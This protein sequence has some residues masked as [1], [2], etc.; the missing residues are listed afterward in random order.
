[1][2]LE[3]A[4]LFALLAGMIFLFLTEK[5]PVD[6]T[7]FAGLLVLV[8]AGYVRPDEAFAGFSSPAVITMLSVFFLSAALQYTGVADAMG[9]RIHRVVGNNEVLLIVAIM[10]VGGV[11]SAF[12]NNIAAAA[13]LLPAVASLA[14]QANIAPSRLMMPLAFG[15]I[16]GGT[17]TLVGT[18]PNLLAGQVLAEQGLE[19]FGL[20]D[21]TPFGLV[22]LAVG[23]LFMITIGR[24]LLPGGAGM[25]AVERADLK[26]V[27]RIEDRLFCLTLPPDSA[28]AGRRLDDAKLS[29]VLGVQVVAIERDGKERLAPDASETLR[30]GDRLLVEGRRGDLEERLELGAVDVEEVGPVRLGATGSSYYAIVL[31]VEPG[32]PFQGRS[33]RQIALRKRYRVAVVGLWRGGESLAEGLATHPLEVGDELLAFGTPERVGHLAARPDLEVLQE[34]SEALG[35]LA[36]GLFVLHVPSGSSLAGTTIGTIGLRERFD[37]TVVGV[38]RAGETEVVVSPDEAIREEDRLVVAGRPGR[39]LQLTKL[40]HVEVTDEPAS[41]TLESEDVGMVEAVVAPRSA[42]VGQSLKALAFRKRYGL[43]ALAVWR[44][45]QPIRSGL[46]DLP[47][48]LGDG[49]LLHGPKERVALLEADP[50]FVVLSTAGPTDPNRPKRAPFAI[51]ALLVMVLLVVTGWFP[52]QVAAFAAATLVVLTRALR[53]HEAYRAVEW[54]AVFLV[55]AIL[56][57]GVAMERSGAAELLAD[58]VARYAGGM[59]PYGVLIALMVLSSLLSQALD[60]APTVVLLAPVVMGTATRLGMSPYP[61]MMAAGLAASA[62]FMTPFSHK[63]NLLVM[64]AGGYRSMDYVKV[65]SPLTV[66]VLAILA[67]MIP[68]LLPFA[69]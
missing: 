56:P 21:F 49:L 29:D 26:S 64:G 17:T 48:R 8:V 38:E 20:F 68:L 2:T 46:P 41:V 18:P 11:L 69:P 16:L 43:R 31:R 35:R 63:A 25:A 1:M 54:R 40:G 51:G 42:A 55:A 12:M 57:V 33:L 66:V 34:G 37:L 44:A 22:L 52:I 9:A 62:A 32:S 28:L 14:R 36:G 65:G 39:I 27:Y 5:L 53:M 50:D 30:G 45:G 4:L 7:A 13:V 23:I 61:L 67:V 58:T 6:L 19:P 10:L 24:K 15:C 59:G 60:G 47:L 3:I